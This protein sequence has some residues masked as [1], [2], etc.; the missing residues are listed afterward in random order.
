MQ[1]RMKHNAQKA[2][3]YAK[4][5][6]DKLLHPVLRQNGRGRGEFYSQLWRS[7]AATV[8]ATYVPLPD[9][10]CE[11]ELNGRVTRVYKG[12]VM[13]DNPVTLKLAGNKPLVHAMLS[14]EGLPVP[15]HV[16]FTLDTLS[17]AWLSHVG[18]ER[19]RD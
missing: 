16:V 6:W 15:R 9:G 11:I 4:Q 19:R 17:V 18:I 8:G 10:F 12:L 3:A 7:A 2:L 5:S 1:H 14:A 13:L